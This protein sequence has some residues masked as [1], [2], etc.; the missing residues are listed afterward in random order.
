LEPHPRSANLNENL[1]SIRLLANKGHLEEA[2]LT[3][4][5]VILSYKLVP[6]LYLLRASILQ[7]LE[8]GNEA[9]KSLKQSIYIDP[10]YIMGHFTLGNLFFRQGNIKYAKRYFN[11]VLELLNTISGDD[12]LAESEGLSANY[13]RGIILANLQ[14]QKSE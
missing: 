13:I 5:E 9:I 12:I 1:I 14:T 11:N 6:E 7:E 2:L 3:C 8:K 10:D 4:N